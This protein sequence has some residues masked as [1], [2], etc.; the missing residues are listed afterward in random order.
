[1]KLDTQ[2]KR[3][4]GLT[5][6]PAVARQYEEIGFDGVWSF[7][8]AHDPFLPLAMAAGATE[9]LQIGTNITVA[10]ARA[11]FAVA[12][13]AWD[14][15]AMSNG[16]FQLGVGTQVRAHVERRFSMPF[17][18]PAARITDYI[19]CLRA[20]WNTFQT[21][22]RPD[23]SGEF[24]RFHLINPF[25]NPGPIA[26]PDIPVYLAGVNTRMCRA[27]GEVAD[28]FHVHPMHS[29][30]YLR[31]VVHPAIA[32]GAKAAGRAASDVAL[33]A[34]VFAVTGESEAERAR[35]EAQVR[36]QVGF[37]AS[38]PNYRA[39][40]EYHGLDGLGKELSALMR[41]GQLDEMTRLVPDSLLSEVAI[42]QADGAIPAQLARRYDGGLLHR[43][44][45]YFPIEGADDPATWKDFVATFRAG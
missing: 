20:I 27:A 38:T 14:L 15:Q 22:A 37:Y 34:S 24:Y 17:D 4:V 18:R 42:S 26:H 16:R 35:S 45:L 41:N 40:L 36:Q 11:P 29:V 43:V 7:E 10:F 19:R 13:T 44:S 31:D 6:I 25:F 39:L 21:G 12:Q 9:R 30:G 2:M 28:G 5:E 33:Y 8:A 1:M 3:D 32:E 23:Y